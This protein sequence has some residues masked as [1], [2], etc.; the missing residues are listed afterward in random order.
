VKKSGG[1]L[2]RFG[3]NGEVL[4]ELTATGVTQ[5]EYVF[6][7]GKRVAKRDTAGN[8]FYY[9]ADELGSSRV[10]VK[11]GTPPTLCYDADFYP[12]G[13]ERSPYTNTCSQNYKFTGKERDAESGLDEFGARYYSSQYGRFI[14][15]DEYPGGPVDLS[16]TDDVTSQALPYADITNPQSLNKYAYTYNNPLRYTDPN[17]HCPWCAVIGALGGV[18]A[19][20]IADKVSG[21][22]ITG[23][24]ILGAAVGGA[25]IGGSAGLASE[26]GIAVQL[27]IAG[28]A[29]LV[30]GVADRTIQ[31]GSLDKAMADPVQMGTDFATNVAGHGITT[32]VE[33]GVAKLSG[34]AVESLSK[35]AEGARTVNRQNKI[36]ARLEGATKKVE[37]KKDVAG[38]AS[39]TTTDT[40][41]KTREQHGCKEDHDGGC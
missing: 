11:D 28:D 34:G 2:Y 16:T 14:T 19:Q 10:I 8:V 35:Q 25:I 21:Q 24:Q 4:A 41:V 20:V 37:T 30:G 22:P 36:A 32:A 15:P 13:G 39:T 33:E 9:F 1:M 23:R 3:P 31:T 7:G 38:A 29:G 12:F 17:G 18:A 6:F 27:A 26:A 5:N 40:V